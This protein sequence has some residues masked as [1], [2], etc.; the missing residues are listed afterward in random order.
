[1]PVPATRLQS[2][3]DRPLRPDGDYVLYWMIAARRAR[4]NFALELV[5]GKIPGAHVDPDALARATGE[6]APAAVCRAFSR[7]LLGEELPER[8]LA[9]MAALNARD[10]THGPRRPQPARPPYEQWLALLLATPQFQW[11]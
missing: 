10:A 8:H 3:N 11:R 4:W 2:L 7:A 1:M 5:Q 9:V 6:T